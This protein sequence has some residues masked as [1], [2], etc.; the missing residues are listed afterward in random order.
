[1]E[2]SSEAKVRDLVADFKLDEAL[3]V[4]IEQAKQQTRRKHNTL[5]VLKGKL[6][7][8]EEQRL[9]GILDA[10]EVGR[11]K[12]E[13]AHQILDIADGSP[14]DHELPQAEPAQVL[15]QK[16]VN[17][18]S[19]SGSSAWIKYMVVGAFLVIALL[20]GVFVSRKWGGENE[21]RPAE[22]TKET[23]A[24]SDGNQPTA[25]S[26][27]TDGPVKLLDF[28]NIKNPF[29][30]LDFVVEF[31]WANAE[32]ISDTEVRLKLRAYLSCK[33][34]LGNCYRVNMLVYA[35]GKPIAPESES[36]LAGWFENG[37]TTSNDL[38]F[39]LP[40]TA[41]EFMLELSRDKSTRKR[42][43][44]MVIDR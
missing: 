14:L 9:A 38:S 20:A 29:T 12:A 39:V 6:A 18:P 31:A 40:V 1:M 44:K 37:S 36:E 21:T 27:A 17:V 10:E 2:N 4:L 8:V 5:L 3:D 41:K 35:D 42:P 30:F 23:K 25:P 34:N 11:Q 24:Q 43:F 28:P 33:S 26:P 7:M 13:I 32:R 19:S 15:V 22:P 16:T